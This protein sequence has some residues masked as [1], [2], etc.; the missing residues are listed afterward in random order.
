MSYRIYR[1][2]FGAP[3]EC[4][5]ELQA[6]QDALGHVNETVGMPA[7]ILFAPACLTAQMGDKRFFQ[8]AIEQNI[9][10]AEFCLFLLK[11]SWGPETRNFASD[12]ELARR[13]AADPAQRPR[14]VA[15]LF[16]GSAGPRTAELS[17]V[18]GDEHIGLDDFRGRVTALV[19]AWM[20]S[21]KAEASEAAQAASDAT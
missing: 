9:R 13:C 8:P 16:D 14:Q 17:A 4:E 1:V 3:I 20:E 11:N 2:F 18:A 10:D 12:F 6:F 15:V 19:T 5:A 7:N 21:V